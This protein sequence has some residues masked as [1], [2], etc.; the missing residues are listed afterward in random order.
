MTAAPPGRAL[1]RHPRVFTL[2]GVV[3]ISF[4]AI[5][6]RL[7]DVSPVTASFY[8]AAYALPVLVVLRWVLPPPPS[9]T[10]RQR[11]FAVLA[12]LAFAADLALWHV[13]IEFIGAGLSTTLGNSQVAMV[14]LAGWIF[15]GERPTPIAIAS[16]PIIFAGV[17]LISGLGQA[18]A[19]GSNPVL[20]A[21]IGV[22]TA[23]LY[24]IYLFLLRSS[25]RGQNIPTV[26]LFEVTLGAAVG[27]LLF[28]P[29]DPEFAF[30]PSW[31]SHGW[32]LLLAVG[33]QVIA[34]LLIAYTLPRIE[35]WESS[36]V[37]VLQ[38]AGTILWAFLIFGETFSAIQ[39][40]GLLLLVG[41]VAIA[42]TWGAR[43]AA[44]RQSDR[45]GRA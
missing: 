29:L 37:L 1:E 40:A 17:V 3:I 25:A 36:V 11:V 27:G 10:T 34:W 32:L 22:I 5:F 35:A 42:S 14:M 12:G 8:R 43:T 16:L 18:D 2:V 4:S 13:G 28:A 19:Y 26:A 6:V 33:A 24:T 45:A 30:A 31:P 41:G 39:W 15:L 21:V 44:P 9:R 38:P 7:A 23:V 20:G